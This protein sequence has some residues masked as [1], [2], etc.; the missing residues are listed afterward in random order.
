MSLEGIVASMNKSRE[1]RIREIGEAIGPERWDT[2]PTSWQISLY[3]N[4]YGAF[5]GWIKWG[6]RYLILVVFVSIAL[7]YGTSQMRNALCQWGIE[8]HC[9]SME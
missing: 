1:A 6:I 3:L 9:Q 7:N 4:E 2:P 5:P 8:G